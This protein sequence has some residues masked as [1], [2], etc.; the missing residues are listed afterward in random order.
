MKSKFIYL[1]ILIP[2]LLLLTV[3]CDGPL[4]EELDNTPSDTDTTLY[5][6]VTDID[7]NQYKTIQ[8]GNQ[9]WMAENLKVTHYNDG[10]PINRGNTYMYTDNEWLNLTEGAY[11]WYDYDVNNYVKYGALY[12]F[13]VARNSKIAPAGWHVPTK[14]EWDQLAAYLGTNAGGKLKST[15]N[16]WSIPNQD[17]TNETGFNAMPARGRGNDGTGAYLSNFGNGALFWSSTYFNE[18]Y[19]WYISLWYTDGVFHKYYGNRFTG[20]S[21]R[22][23]KD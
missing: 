2:S 5:Q 9:T 8:I 12:N 3:S 4:S 14:E 7:G 1:F 23:I 11:C 10:T 6:K 17:A 18:Q 21:I 16:I 15:S 13:E 19:A 20:M 22:C